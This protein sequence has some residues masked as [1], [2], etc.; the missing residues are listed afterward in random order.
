MNRRST[1][2]AAVIWLAA[3]AAFVALYFL[4]RQ[5]VLHGYLVG[6]RVLVSLPLGA[7]PLLMAGEL[8]SGAGPRD[9]EPAI[10][11]PLR[12]MLAGL[13]L[14][15]LLA[16]PILLMPAYFYGWVPSSRAPE[17]SGYHGLAAH[18]F[19]P[20]FFAGRGLVYLVAW[21]ALAAV[22]VVPGGSPLRR[23]LAIAGLLIHLVIGTFAA[24]DWVMSLDPSSISSAYGVIVIAAQAVLAAAVAL[25]MAHPR[26]RV[27]YLEVVALLA[28]VALATYMQFAQYL[29]VWSA[30]LP[31][32]IAWYQT[33]W[34]DI[35]GPLFTVGAP[36]L[37]VLATAVLLPEPL[38]MRRLPALVG[39]V[40]ILVVAVFDLVC[41]ASP[42][43]T[44]TAGR[45]GLD[46][47]GVIAVAG[48][49]AL[50]ALA[51]DGLLVRR[52]RHG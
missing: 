19:T 50:C 14:L 40:A 41:L 15:A 23:S 7:L 21:L 4:D 3:L 31:K 34:R 38:A 28:L 42:G 39:L 6:W 45:V 46:C 8:I 35:V 24:Y 52:V 37:L 11:P 18:W 25:L 27:R 17:P 26:G 13:P 49:A 32:E 33:R 51:V 16:L 10:M 20:A 5:G 43:R 2:V 29:V 12:L 48:L 1:L 36:V 30:N 47:L 22:F 9:A 44:F